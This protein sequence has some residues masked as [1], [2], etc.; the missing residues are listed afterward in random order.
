M[1]LTI[2]PILVAVL[3]LFYGQKLYWLFVGG[4]GFIVAMDLAARWLT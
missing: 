3:L 4:I 1:E 2:F